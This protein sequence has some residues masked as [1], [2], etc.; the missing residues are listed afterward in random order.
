MRY[1]IYQPKKVNFPEPSSGNN[2]YSMYNDKSMCRYISKQTVERAIN[3]TYIITENLPTIDSAIQDLA[4]AN[5]NSTSDY[6]YVT[7]L[8][9][10]EHFI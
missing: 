3:T 7:E 9:Y 5:T 4:E 10:P 6:A 1:I 8:D 2:P